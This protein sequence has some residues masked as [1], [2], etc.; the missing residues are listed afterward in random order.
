MKSKRKRDDEGGESD[1]QE[2][3]LPSVEFSESPML[4]VCDLLSPARSDGR[5]VSPLIGRT[6]AKEEKVGRRGARVYEAF[7]RSEQLHFGRRITEAH[8]ILIRGTTLP[9][10]QAERTKQR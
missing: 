1:R 8:E 10:R 6:L 3:L 9:P 7:S 5:K 4:H 2:T